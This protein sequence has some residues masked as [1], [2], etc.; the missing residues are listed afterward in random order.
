MV[1]F[2]DFEKAQQSSFDAIVS[3]VAQDFSRHATLSESNQINIEF[4]NYVKR[5]LRGRPEILNVIVVDK[6]GH[7]ALSVAPELVGMDYSQHAEIMN[8]RLGPRLEL[9]SDERSSLTATYS[10]RMP[11]SSPSKTDYVVVLYINMLK[12]RLIHTAKEKSVIEPFRIFFR[13]TFDGTKLKFLEICLVG[14][15][16]SK[17]E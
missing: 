5:I 9:P 1:R 14:A 17:D 6:S 16:N 4:R 2:S 8:A 11:V 3:F 12:C 13:T 10:G 7:V 15:L